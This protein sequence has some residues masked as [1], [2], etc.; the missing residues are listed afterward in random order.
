MKKLLLLAFAMLCLVAAPVGAWTD[1][2]ETATI[3]VATSPDN[4]TSTAVTIPRGA[5]GVSVY[6]PTITSSTVSLKVSH[7]G[8][9]TYDDLFC[10]E[11]GTNTIL[12][13]S[14]AGTGG[15]YLQAPVNCN[16][17]FYNRLKVF[18]GS[19]QAADR[20]FK[21]IFKKPASKSNN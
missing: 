1:G 8:G 2:V 12:W 9:T 17:G 13:S 5:E 21:V 7:D 3:T 18:C 15:M 20:A 11:N 10:E 19:A 6:V 16:I 14:A 4:V